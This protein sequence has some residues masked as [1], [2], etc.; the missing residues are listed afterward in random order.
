MEK[1]DY[2]YLVTLCNGL[3]PGIRKEVDVA[4]YEFFV[5]AGMMPTLILRREL[6]RTVFS[7]NILK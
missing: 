2:D 4:V 1:G 5:E 7:S 3:F 6:R